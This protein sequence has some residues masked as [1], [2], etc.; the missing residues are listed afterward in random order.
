MTLDALV[1]WLRS[2]HPK[3]VLIPVP[4]GEKRPIFPYRHDEWTWESFDAFIA[5]GFNNVDWAIILKDLC[6]VDAD[7][8]EV[9]ARLESAFPVLRQVPAEKTRRGTH[10]FFRRSAVAD[11]Q[12]YFDCCGSQSV[13]EHVDFKSITQTGTGGIIVVSPSTDKVWLRE[14]WHLDELQSIPDALLQ[15]VAWPTP[16]GSTVAHAAQLRGTKRPLTERGVSREAGSSAEPVLADAPLAAKKI[17]DAS[18]NT[19][20][21]DGDEIKK[22]DPDLEDEAVQIAFDGCDCHMH[23]SGARL[24][25]LRSSH[26]CAALLS[27]RWSSADEKIVKIKLPCEHFVCE[28]LFH[29]LEHGTLEVGVAPHVKLLAELDAL[30]DML[31]F[32]PRAKNPLLERG[33]FFA[34]LYRISPEWWLCHQQE[35]TRMLCSC[36]ADSDAALIPIN[37]ARARCTGYTPLIKDDLWLFKSL[38]HLLDADC[39]DCCVYMADPAITLLS[40]LPPVV[41]AILRR[42]ATCAVVAGGAV[43]G[44]VSKFIGQGTDV[45]IFLYGLGKEASSAALADIEAFV[46]GGEYA[47]VYDKSISPA[48]VTYTKKGALKPYSGST[49][50][51]LL[52]RP[53]QIVLGLHRARSQ[54]LE[55][56]DLAPT[57]VLAR[58]DPAARSTRGRLDTLIVEA[59][60]SF[61][62]AMQHHAF[63]VDCMYWSP[64]S[65]AR[66]TK[67][68]AKGFECAVPGVRREAFVKAITPQADHF[69]SEEKHDWCSRRIS[70]AEPGSR[71]STYKVTHGPS[72]YRTVKGLGMLFVAES[73]VLMARQFL[74][75]GHKEEDYVEIIDG[76]L[77]PGEAAVI[78]SKV[79]GTLGSGRDRAPTQPAPLHAPQHRREEHYDIFDE[80][81]VWQDEDS[82]GFGSLYSLYGK[83]HGTGTYGFIREAFR[84][85]LAVRLGDA[86]RGIGMDKVFTLDKV[87]WSFTEAGRFK[88]EEAHLEALYEP[89]A[90]ARAA[91]DEVQRR[92]ALAA[93][94]ESDSEED[95]ESNAEEESKNE[96]AQ[97]AELAIKDEMAQL[98]GDAR[99][100]LD[101]ASKSALAA[102]QPNDD[103]HNVGKASS[104]LLTND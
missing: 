31:G 59:L 12:C 71:T 44:G 15:A 89:E 103:G 36:A 13:L 58:I 98:P 21:E 14:P 45:D 7:D 40:Q 54:V 87:F 100:E 65:V 27:G 66:I 70:G 4:K 91:V 94:I 22:R 33:Q 6:V 37:A 43:L 93:A 102:R 52:D 55:Y 96:C 49:D 86:R 82:D 42:H 95:A 77:E 41:V 9:A 74:N 81:D 34:D 47:D 68:V 75:D 18:M 88:P 79:A 38:P 76:R 17:K 5:T 28:Q 10:Y 90:L 29:L 32:P 8:P 1:T 25:F 99:A 46:E 78:A 101:S 92:A 97:G 69:R 72:S 60:P 62:L 2:A 51:W 63:F 64:A 30:V 16:P 39:E 20:E 104:E 56:F 67:Y 61:D 19:D 80:E 24:E 35:Q 83:G 73:E 48:A 26:Y 85:D 84:R 53:F 11:E 50:A 57:K 3:N 23:V